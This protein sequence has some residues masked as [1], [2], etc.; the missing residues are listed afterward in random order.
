MGARPLRQSNVKYGKPTKIKGGIPTI[1]LCNPGPKSS[2]KEYLDEAN[3]AALKQWAS[4]NAKFYTLKEPLFS[5]VNQGTTQ[6]R[7]EESNSTISN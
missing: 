2:Y 4:K 1:F 3:N 7:Q 5:S 6:G